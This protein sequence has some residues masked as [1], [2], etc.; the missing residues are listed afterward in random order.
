MRHLIGLILALALAAAVFFAGGWGAEHVSAL[1]GHSVGL[2]SK[3]GLIGLA[4]V[5]GPGLLLGILIPRPP[6]SPPASPLPVGPPCGAS[7]TTPGQPGPR[8]NAPSRTAR[9]RWSRPAP[10][11]RSPA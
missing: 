6:F 11:W 10:P 2:P 1:A 3:T 7:V 8:V 4:A 5:L 9:F